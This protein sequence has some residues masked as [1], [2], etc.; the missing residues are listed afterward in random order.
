MNEKT[1]VSSS[2]MLG[3]GVFVVDGE[4]GFCA[5]KWWGSDPHHFKAIKHEI[6]SLLNVKSRLF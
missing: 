1:P 5:L 6:T 4:E 2:W 3:A